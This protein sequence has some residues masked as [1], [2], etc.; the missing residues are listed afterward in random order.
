MAAFAAAQAADPNYTDVELPRALLDVADHKL[1]D[2]AS[3]LKKVADG[4]SL[5]ARLLLGKV[6]ERQGN[7]E[8]ALEE[9]KKVVNEDGNNAEALN[10]LAYLLA[11]YGNQPDEA[12][13]H[14]QKARE[15]APDNPEYADTLG[16]ILYRKGLY[17]SAIIQLGRAAS[18]E[19]NAVWKY[20]LAMAYVKGGDLTRGRSTLNN[21]LK[22]NPNLPE[23]K[24]AKAMVEADK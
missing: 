16:W 14:A 15:L 5:Q 11:E 18:H 9:F 4:G 1:D 20:H 21:A 23:A 3:R 19:G 10:N 8:A 24:M 13:K 6:R 12:L 7:H 2:A 22:L 17:S